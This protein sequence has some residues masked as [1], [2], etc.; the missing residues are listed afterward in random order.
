MDFFSA[1]YGWRGEGK[2]RSASLKSLLTMMKLDIVKPYPKKI[3][4]LYESRDILL[5][6]C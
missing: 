2:K 5:K 4:N 6:S 3:Q 1:A